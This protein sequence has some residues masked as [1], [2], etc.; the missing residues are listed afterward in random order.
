MRPAVVGPKLPDA[1]P[2][3]VLAGAGVIDGVVFEIIG[4]RAVL[5]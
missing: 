1:M 2:S 5:F 3:G 4:E